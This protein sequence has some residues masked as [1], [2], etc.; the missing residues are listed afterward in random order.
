MRTATDVQTFFI[1]R[2]RTENSARCLPAACVHGVVQQ[3]QAR[4]APRLADVALNEGV[5]LCRPGALDQDSAHGPRVQFDH[6]AVLTAELTQPGV[7]VP[8][9]DG[10]EERAGRDVR[11]AARVEEEL[12]DLVRDGRDAAA[13]AQRRAHR[14]EELGGGRRVHVDVAP[15]E[16]GGAAGPLVRDEEAARAQDARYLREKPAIVTDLRRLGGERETS[17]IVPSKRTDVRPC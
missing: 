14:P 17:T 6:V 16:H 4:D 10:H 5:R 13:V 1:D 2:V 7:G 3:T 9:A 15:V 12:G 8:A 11:E